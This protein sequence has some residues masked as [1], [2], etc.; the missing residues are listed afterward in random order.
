MLGKPVY[1]ALKTAPPHLSSAV[2]FRAVFWSYDNQDRRCGLYR[3][4]FDIH[5][6]SR[7]T[8]LLGL[9]S[10]A[11]NRPNGSNY[12]SQVIHSLKQPVNGLPVPGS[13][14]SCRYLSGV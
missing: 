10:C 5:P 8:H 13:A 3:L 2:Q 4:R 6:S 14:F 12:Y 1:I 9:A 11:S 7:L